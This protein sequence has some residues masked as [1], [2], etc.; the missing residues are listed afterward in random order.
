MTGA[1]DYVSDGTRTIAIE[2]GDPLLEAITG[3]GCMVTSVVA[4][5]ASGKISILFSRSI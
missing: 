4:C 3:S 2:N 1:I 5:Y